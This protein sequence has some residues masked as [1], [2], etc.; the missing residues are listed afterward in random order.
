ML[1]IEDL[2]SNGKKEP[3]RAAD[4]SDGSGGIGDSSAADGSLENKASEPARKEAESERITR[5]RESSPQQPGKAK[6]ELSCC[7][8][9]KAVYQGAGEIPFPRIILLGATGVGKSTLG[10]QLLGKPARNNTAFFC[11]QCTRHVIDLF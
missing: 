3:L 7:Q 9:A 5:A 2:E 11:Q 10:N 4:V 6:V 1:A 8:K